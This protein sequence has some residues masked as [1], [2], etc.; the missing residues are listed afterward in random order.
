VSAATHTEEIRALC[1]DYVKGRLAREPSD[2][3]G[4]APRIGIAWQHFR[5]ASSVTTTA[6]MT[7][8]P[9]PDHGAALAVRDRRV[10]LGLGQRELAIL[11]SCALSTV[12]NIEAGLIPR[13]SEVLPRI[14]DSLERAERE[15]ATP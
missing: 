10:A 8:S 2:G 13:R 3:C 12:A 5:S 6:R 11:A 9:V 14:L 15:A 1:G 7:T 4:R